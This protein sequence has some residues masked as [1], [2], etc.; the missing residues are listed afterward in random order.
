[1]TPDSVHIE[2]LELF[3]RVGVT[4][5]ER[6]NPQR[7]VANITWSPRVVPDDLRDDVKRTVN[8]S[9]LCAEIKEFAGARADKLIETLAEE[10]GAHLLKKF[11]IRMLTIEL[12][13]FVL[14]DAAYVS[15]TITRGAAIH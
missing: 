13:K 6:E 11:P 10:L 12:R 5:A 4:E 3:A 2:Q 14:T 7:L 15:V 1:M 8:Y 9:E